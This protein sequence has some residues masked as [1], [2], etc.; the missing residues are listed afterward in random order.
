M[1]TSP[2]TH[3]SLVFRIEWCGNI[4]VYVP[5]APVRPSVHTVEKE[6]AVSCA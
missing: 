4:K 1:T 6:T 5:I 3:P 2:A